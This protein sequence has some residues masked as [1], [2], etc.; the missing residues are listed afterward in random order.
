MEFY[1]EK[2]QQQLS[3]L[4]RTHFKSVASIPRAHVVR[5]KTFSLIVFV[6]SSQR[7]LRPP[8]SCTAWQLL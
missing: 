3:N 2:K 5:S 1:E 6:T 7:V 8:H 4:E